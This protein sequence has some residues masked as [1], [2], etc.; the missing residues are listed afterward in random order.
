MVIG[1]KIPQQQGSVLWGWEVKSP[2]SAPEFLDMRG[3]EVVHTH[4]LI[5]GLVGETAHI[6][7]AVCVYMWHSVS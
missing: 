7:V 4:P 1:S 2:A 3:R 6:S 5:P